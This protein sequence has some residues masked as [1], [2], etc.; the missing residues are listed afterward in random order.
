MAENNIPNYDEL[1]AALLKKAVGYEA[2]EVQC[3]YVMADSGELKLAKKKVTTKH[4]PADI[5]A[6][7]MLIE[8]FADSNGPDYSKFSDEELDKEVIKLM[9]EYQKMTDINLAEEA[10]GG[11]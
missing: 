6:S 11:N 8:N 5:S 2:E 10:F 3:E 9:R 4:Y 1:K 7:K